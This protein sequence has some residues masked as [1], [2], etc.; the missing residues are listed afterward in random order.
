MGQDLRSKALVCP[1]ELEELDLQ[2]R[3]AGQNF[4]E[5]FHSSQARI[6]DLVPSQ[7]QTEGA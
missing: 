6:K 5:Q 1:D 4:L 2:G 3:G 7:K